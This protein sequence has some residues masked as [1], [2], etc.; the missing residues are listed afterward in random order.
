MLKKYLAPAV[1][2][3]LAL[4]LTHQPARAQSRDRNARPPEKIRAD[5][6]LIGPGERVQ[7]KLRGGESL[8]GYVSLVGEQEFV[9]TKAKE[10]TKRTI[11][12]ADV[13]RVK[14]KNEKRVSTAGKILI[15]MGVMWAVGMVATGG[16]G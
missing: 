11:A 7:V 10:G 15:V 5:V 9:L 16:G 14:V 1:A 4:L 2:V 12:Y 8:T 13:S 6:A 3:L